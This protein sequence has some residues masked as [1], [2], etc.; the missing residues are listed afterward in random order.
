MYARFKYIQMKRQQLKNELNVQYVYI[1]V[2]VCMS[3]YVHTQNCLTSSIPTKP[4]NVK[5][6]SDC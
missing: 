5:Q 3:V 4:K 1:C 2:Y 6:K